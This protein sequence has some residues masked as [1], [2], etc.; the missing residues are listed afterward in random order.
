[1]YRLLSFSVEEGFGVPPESFHA[2]GARTCS[3]NVHRD[4]GLLIHE[5][6]GF[7]VYGSLGL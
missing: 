7:L 1:M 6:L 2:D 5:F 4:A 3:Y